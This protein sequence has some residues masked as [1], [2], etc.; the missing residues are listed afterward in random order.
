MKIKPIE[1]IDLIRVIIIRIVILT[2]LI[3]SGL[4]Y[5]YYFGRNI[6]K[7][8]NQ[9]LSEENKKS[10]SFK[11]I[12]LKTESFVKKI[13]N[14]SKEVVDNVLGEATK[15][16]QNTT[17]T[18]ASRSSEIVNDLIFNSTIKPILDQYEKLPQ[19]QKE[20]IKEDICK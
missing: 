6:K 8:T 9:V 14:E 2:S 20:K 15:V 4:G 1:K 13:T 18:I 17:Q 12:D 3:I 19:E 16:Y 11:D 5:Y 7:D 10:I